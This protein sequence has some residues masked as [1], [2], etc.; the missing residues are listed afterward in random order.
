M[1]RLYI[2]IKSIY[3][4]TIHCFVTLFIYY[5]QVNTENGKLKAERDKLTKLLE[6]ERQK[7]EDLMFRNEE[8]NINKEDYNVICSILVV[9]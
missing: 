4:H 6:D 1:H 2:Q 9:K 8:E 7:V 5:F 3:T